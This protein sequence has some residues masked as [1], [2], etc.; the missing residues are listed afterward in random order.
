M[1]ERIGFG[2]RLGAEIIDAILI[3]IGGAILGAVLGGVLGSTLGAGM[4]ATS[5]EPEGAAIGGAL[6]GLFGAL[7]GMFLGILLMA[8]I[9]AVWE[10]LTGAALGKRALGIKIKSD[11]GSPAPVPQ[12]LARSL[13][14]HNGQVLGLVSI[15]TGVEAIDTAGDVGNSIMAIGCLLVIGS[16][17]Q[18]FHDMFAGT[19]VFPKD[20]AVP[21]EEHISEGVEG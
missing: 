8:I 10:G 11:D 21:V 15:A 16:K 17:K 6:G 2:R 5:S 20:K 7:A 13:V 18:A 19:A 1:A 12:L 14:K 9:V 3:L 4:G